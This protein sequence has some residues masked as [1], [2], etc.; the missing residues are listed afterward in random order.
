MIFLVSTVVVTPAGTS[1]SANL[2]LIETPKEK[3][4]FKIGKDRL[5]YIEGELGVMT[6]EIGDG[7]VKVVDSPCKDKYCIKQG[8]ISASGESIV[9]LPG[10]VKITIQGETFTD[11]INR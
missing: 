5:V 9:C 11:S 7:F 8:R 6:V 1:S 10:K 3:K 2:I 4:L